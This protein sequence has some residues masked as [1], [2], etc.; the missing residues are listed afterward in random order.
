M[1]TGS[2]AGASRR[3]R[4]HPTSSRSA[5]AAWLRSW[6]RPRRD[7][8]LFI[9]VLKYAKALKDDEADRR[10]RSRAQARREARA[11]KR[12][13]ELAKTH[14]ELFT[15]ELKDDSGQW[16]ARRYAQ[17]RV[18]VALRA[19]PRGRAASTRLTR[20]VG[21]FSLEIGN[22]QLATV[23]PVVLALVS[24]AVRIKRPSGLQAA[25]LA[26]MAG[27][28]PVAPLPHQQVEAERRWRARFASA[29]T[30]NITRHALFDH[31]LSEKYAVIFEGDKLVPRRGRQT[32][33]TT[34]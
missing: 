24:R 4:E 2:R 29:T 27:I 20:A 15:V 14:P 18:D 25:V 34:G 17:W 6:K 8:R 7:L 3:R 12:V 31:P 32:G 33:Q 11:K 5:A 26:V 23:A 22:I 30:T 21:T 19:Y 13:L 1:K 9:E 28:E 16:W 10:R